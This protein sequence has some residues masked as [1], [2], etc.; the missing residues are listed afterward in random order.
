VQNDER[1]NR[2]EERIAWLERH[3]VA[4]DRAM[5]ELSEENSRLKIELSSL[6]SRVSGGSLPGDAEAGPISEERPPHY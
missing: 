2:I 4:Q 1:L 3:V 5:L 6:R